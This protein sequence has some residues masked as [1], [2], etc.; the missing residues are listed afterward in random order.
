[1]MTVSTMIQST[2]C[3]IIEYANDY[4]F[5]GIPNSMR[6]TKVRRKHW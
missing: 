6:D 5:I 3:D 4:V 1:M 2:G